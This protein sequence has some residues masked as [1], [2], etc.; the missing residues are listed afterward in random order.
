LVITVAVTELPIDQQRSRDPGSVQ[1][2]DEKN[3]RLCQG[4]SKIREIS[5]NGIRGDRMADQVLNGI[6]R[7]NQI[8]TLSGTFLELRIS[9]GRIIT[10]QCLELS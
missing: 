1:W 6:S 10:P 5:P 9:M 3:Q 4:A 8:R 7:F 2:N